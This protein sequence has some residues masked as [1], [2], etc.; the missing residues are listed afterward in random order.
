MN[1]HRADQTTRTAVESPAAKPPLQGGRC[2]ATKGRGGDR[3]E[4]Y[5]L[6]R[7]GCGLPFPQNKIC[8]L[9]YFDGEPRPPSPPS[10]PPLSP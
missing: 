8:P 9:F 5:R 2:S 6:P 4:D 3:D 10:P 7:Q 1:N